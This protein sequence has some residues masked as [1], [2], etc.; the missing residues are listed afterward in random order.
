MTPLADD[1]R[2]MAPNRAPVDAATRRPPLPA[3]P[4]LVAGATEMGAV[5]VLLLLR[6][7]GAAL[8]LAALLHALSALPLAAAATSISSE[9]TLAGALGLAV[10]VFGL[11]LAALA[12]AT[13]ARNEL[14]RAAG[15]GEARAGAVAPPLD[16]EEVRRMA[17]AVPCCEAMLEGPAEERRAIIA[18]LTRRADAD[19]VA[20]LRWA[21]GAADADLAV[22]AALALEEVSATFEGR[23]ESARR[24]MRE[25]PSFEG[26]LA[27]A[28]TVARAV[29]A[30]VADPALVPS[31]AREARGFFDEAARLG[32]GPGDAVA[33]GRARLE[34]AVLR[35]DS[36][37]ACIDAALAGEGAPGH[38]ELRA[39]REEAVLASHILP[40]EGPSALATY[41]PAAAAA[42]PPPLTAR[43]RLAFG[44]SSRRRVPL[45][46]AQTSLRS[47]VIPLSEAS[48]ERD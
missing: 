32:P 27:A 12:L 7:S 33:I 21:L 10:P 40:W 44:A 6:G 43:R 28:E 25:R 39:L 36:A 37:L 35:P 45:A 11:P 41:H 2:A 46:T 22:E 9:R 20:L 24:E 16:P 18:T 1:A 38:L 14:A 4:W 31:L 34:L 29:D 48:H 13:T 5:A 15:H 42:G 19:A 8:V 17:E 30:G 26:A 3:L 23:L 47:T